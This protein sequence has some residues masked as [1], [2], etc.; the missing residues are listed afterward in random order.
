MSSIQCM[1]NEDALLFLFYVSFRLYLQLKKEVAELTR[2]RDIAQSLV[3]KVLQVD[4][5]DMSS[6]EFVRIFSLR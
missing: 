4:G 6:T 3:K 5:D 1:R 2:Q